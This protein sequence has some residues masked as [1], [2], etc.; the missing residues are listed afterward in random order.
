MG[1]DVVTEGGDEALL[2]GPLGNQLPQAALRILAAEAWLPQGRHAIGPVLQ[3]LFSE[4][5]Q[6]LLLLG[7]VVANA[8]LLAELPGVLRVEQR[9]RC[10]LR[11][12]NG[13]PT[14]TGL[15]NSSTMSM[16]SQEAT[17]IM[18]D[19]RYMHKTRCLGPK[20]P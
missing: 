8:E 18:P 12:Q 5:G 3:R 10:K 15:P 20:H 14:Q 11:K 17:R 4:A 13:T 16:A 6:R 1:D 2:E 19:A 7:R 9:P